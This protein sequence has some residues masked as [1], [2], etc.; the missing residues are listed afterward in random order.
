MSNAVENIRTIDGVVVST[1]MDK[2]IVVVVESQR[3]HPLYGKI[4]RRR[5][6]FYAHNELPVK[7]GDVVRL[8]HTR[9]LSKLKRWKTVEVVSSKSEQ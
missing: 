1:K 5:T 8:V 7:V 2:T 9:P 4:V 3:R 6:R